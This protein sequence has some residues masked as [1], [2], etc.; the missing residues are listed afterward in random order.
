MVGKGN[1][2]TVLPRPG[3]RPTVRGVRKHGLFMTNV[4]TPRRTHQVSHPDHLEPTF[5]VRYECG[6]SLAQ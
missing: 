5:A 2:K 4:N 3:Y 6:F 1:T